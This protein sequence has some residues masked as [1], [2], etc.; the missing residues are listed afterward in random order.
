MHH[1]LNVAS[2]L[3]Q[4]RQHLDGADQALDQGKSEPAQQELKATHELD[5][6]IHQLIQVT[7]EAT[8][9]IAK[10]AGHLAGPTQAA[11]EGADQ[12]LNPHQVE[13]AWAHQQLTSLLDTLDRTAEV[14]MD[15]V[16]DKELAALQGAIATFEERIGSVTKIDIER[17]QAIGRVTGSEAGIGAAR[18][19]LFEGLQK[20]GAL[21]RKSVV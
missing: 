6:S 16:P 15:K 7:R 9:A 12:A 17:R 14:M 18:Q 5:Q 19:Q 3:A 13:T 4:A 2:E 8:G 20:A 1:R 10:L 11:V 21:D